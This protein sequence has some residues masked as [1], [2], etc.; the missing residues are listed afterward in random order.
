MLIFG[1]LPLT[2]KVSLQIQFTDKS[3]GVPTSWSWD[4][5]DKST[6]TDKNP[7]HTYS[8]AGKYTVS[9]TVKNELGSNTRKIS[10]YIIVKKFEK[11]IRF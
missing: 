11:E 4:F 5:G 9:L 10:K 3:T 2:G 6:S 8:K 7:V 1:Q